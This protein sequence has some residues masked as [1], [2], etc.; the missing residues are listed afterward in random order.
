MWLLPLLQGPPTQTAC[1]L[2][3]KSLKWECGDL[4]SN[5]I[6]A[7]ATPQFSLVFPKPQ[8]PLLELRVSLWPWGT[9]PTLL[10]SNH[11]QIAAAMESSM[12]VPQNTKNRTTLWYRNATSAY[13]PKEKQKHELEKIY[14]P[15]GSLL[16]YL[17]EPKYGSNLSVHRWINGQRRRGACARWKI[18]QT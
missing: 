2:N 14:A 3:N 13:Y 12:E 10:P 9:S 6:S 1:S 8:A 17:Q 16:H 4:Y 5:F 11:S 15:S 7:L 18:I